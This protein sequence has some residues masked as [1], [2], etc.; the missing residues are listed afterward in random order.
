MKYPFLF[1]FAFS[2]LLFSCA[3]ADLRSV[4][5]HRFVQDAPPIEIAELDVLSTIIFKNELKRHTLHFIYIPKTDELQMNFRNG[6]GY[7]RVFLSKEAREEMYFA[8]ENYNRL[9]E[10]KSLIENKKTL[11]SLGRYPALHQ[12]GG[13]GKSYEAQGVTSLKF[14]YLFRDKGPWFTLTISV[15]DNEL[16]DLSLGKDIFKSS[17]K[18]FYLNRAMCKELADYL[19][20]EYIV[21]TL[22]KNIDSTEDKEL[23]IGD[24]EY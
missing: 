6:T 23:I 11:E 15:T 4:P 22:F 3:S 7:E 1:L 20:D 13:A 19:S 21:G 9:F 5:P 16:V 2:A 12:F 24:T 14:G 8:I 18:T 10:T 17:P